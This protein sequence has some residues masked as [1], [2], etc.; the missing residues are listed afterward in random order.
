MCTRSSLQDYMDL[1]GFSHVCCA[2]G[3]CDLLTSCSYCWWTPEMMASGV[4]IGDKTNYNNIVDRNWW[5]NAKWFH[6]LL[7]SIA[8]TTVLHSP[9]E[10]WNFI[11]FPQISIFV[12]FLIL[13]SLVLFALQSLVLGSMVMFYFLSI[14]YSFGLVSLFVQSEN[15]ICPIWKCVLSNLRFCMLVL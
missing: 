8:P 12:C 11:S 2:A 14:I 7:C 3:L 4:D 6:L 1:I 15:K 5:S 13:F 10:S 9:L